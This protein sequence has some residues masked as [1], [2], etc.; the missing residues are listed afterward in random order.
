M[1]KI[2]YRAKL[3]LREYC[4]SPVNVLMLNLLFWSTINLLGMPLVAVND[5]LLV[6]S[7]LI[8][9]RFKKWHFLINWLKFLQR[10][11]K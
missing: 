7:I 3:V 5:C 4:K 10:S 6:S 8:I 2:L 1:N 11:P 9:F